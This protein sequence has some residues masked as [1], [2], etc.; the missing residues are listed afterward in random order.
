MLCLMRTWG[1]HFCE[2]DYGH[3]GLHWTWFSS[4]YGWNMWWEE[5]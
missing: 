4:E 3:T 2:L 5:R 1:G